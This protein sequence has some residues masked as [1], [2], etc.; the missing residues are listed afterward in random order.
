[1]ILSQWSFDRNEDIWDQFH[2]EG[3]RNF[4]AYQSETVDEL[5]DQARNTT[6]PQ[7]KKQSLRKIHR[8]LQDETPMVFLWTL[9]SYSA[10]STRI[11]NVVIHPFYF[12]TWT[13]DWTLD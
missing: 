7:L 12:F 11:E 13:R 4:I 5:L 3:S 9:D 1:L 8:I 6:D 2:S 10:M